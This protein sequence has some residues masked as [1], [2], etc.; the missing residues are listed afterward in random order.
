MKNNIILGVFSIILI[1]IIEIISSIVLLS[2]L[3]IYVLKG[4]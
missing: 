4:K 2:K 3:A 1:I